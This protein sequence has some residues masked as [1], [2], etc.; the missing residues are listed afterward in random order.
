MI[1]KCFGLVNNQFQGVLSERLLLMALS[2]SLLSL[3]KILRIQR[4]C[5]VVLCQLIF[6]HGCNAQCLVAPV[7]ERG[8]FLVSRK[9]RVLGSWG[10]GLAIASGQLIAR[11]HCA[12]RLPLEFMRIMRIITQEEE[13]LRW[14]NI[15]PWLPQRHL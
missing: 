3:E 10:K 15:L 2:L 13:E 4:P 12:A 14:R 11:F 7:V 1:F 6:P 9:S 8:S 5:T